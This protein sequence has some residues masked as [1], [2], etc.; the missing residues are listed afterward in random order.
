MFYYI[1]TERMRNIDCYSTL[2]AFKSACA[3]LDADEIRYVTIIA[4]SAS[5]VINQKIGNKHTT[6]V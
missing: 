2:D 5:V 6:W 4:N 3:K 1:V